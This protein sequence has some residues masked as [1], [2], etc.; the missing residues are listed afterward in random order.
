MNK[1]FLWIFLDILLIIGDYYQYKKTNE[2]YYLF[3]IFGFTILI[4][5]WL[6]RIYYNIV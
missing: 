2:W 4:F 6:Y 3:F 5:V 1:N